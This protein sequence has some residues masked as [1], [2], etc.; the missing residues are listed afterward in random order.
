MLKSLNLIGKIPQAVVILVAFMSILAGCATDKAARQ[1]DEALTDEAKRITGLSAAEDEDE[2]QIIIQGNR[3]LTYTS[4]KQNLPLGVLFYFPETAV[5]SN[6]PASV[7]PDNAV[8]DSVEAAVLDDQQQMT[9]I[10]IALKQDIPYDVTPQ[11]TGIRITFPKPGS[12][13]SVSAEMSEGSAAPETDAATMAAAPAAA[14]MSEDTGKIPA[15]QLKSVFVTKFE[16]RLQINVNANGSIADYKDFTIGN[17]ARIVFDLPGL[18]SPFKGQQVVPVKSEFVRQVRHFGY[19]DKVRLVVDTNNKYLKAYT[20]QTVKNGLVIQ[21]GS[22]SAAFVE[23]SPA[24]DNRTAAAAAAAVPAAPAAPQTAAAAETSAPVYSDSGKPAWINRIDFVSKE[25]G[26]STI[27]IGT[28]RPVKYELD[29]ATDRLLQLKLYDTNLPRYRKRPLITTRFDSAVNRITPIQKPAMRNMSIIAIELREAVAYDVKENEDQLLISFAPSSIP[30]KPMD[31]AELPDWKKVLAQAEAQAP[32]SPE[33][34]TEMKPE[35]GPAAPPATTGADAAGQVPTPLPPPATVEKPAEMPSMP[36]PLPATQPRSMSTL[37]MMAAGQQP[38]MY[39]GEKIALDFYETDIKNVFRIIRE[40]SGKNFAIDKNVNG[41]VTLTLERPVPWDQVLDLVLKMNSLG[42]AMEGDIIRIATLATLTKEE[43]ARRAQIASMQKSKQ[44][45][46]SLEPL[47]TRYISVNYSD[48]R[49]E[50]LPHVSKVLTP[51]RGSITVDQRNNQLI[52]TDVAEVVDRVEQIVEQIDTVTPQVII[53][54]KVV[55]VNREFSQNVGIEWSGSSEPL[56][57][58]NGG[59]DTLAGDVAMNFPAAGAGSTIG[60]SF[61]KLTGTPLQLDATLNAIEA[62]QEGRIITAP[63][64]VTLDNKKA[65][66]KQGVEFPYLERDASGNATV[67]FKNIDLLLDVTPIV[68]PDDRILLKI[69]ITKNDIGTIVSGV[70]SLNTNEAQTELLV[71][72]G[73]TIVIGGIIKTNVQKSNQGWPGLKDVPLFGW[74]FKTQGITD[75][76][77]ELLIFITPRIVQLEQRRLS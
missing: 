45:E 37:E 67:K 32:M 30:P 47:I 7:T 51:N 77:N 44:V 50:I 27:I 59:Q 20:A 62:K 10:L 36:A 24:P 38:T 66:I 31:Q 53:E 56:W 33:T 6:V 4:V 3:Q 57:S 68:T 11:G 26:R 73:D 39:T 15:T 65:V 2:Y 61:S 64:I 16:N 9:R 71:N 14:D 72:D 23:P 74:L 63:K 48:A 17:P 70:P 76:T 29:K 42:M 18:K 13:R 58:Q 34:A 12:E 75:N 21:V 40:I 41:N 22:P 52:V 60:I 8:I 55:E 5:A 43:A 46:K 69:L 28:T 25:E 49:S 19:S 1:A 35:S 54:A